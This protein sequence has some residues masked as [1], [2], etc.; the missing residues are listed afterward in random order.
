MQIQMM[1]ELN[2][3]YMVVSGEEIEKC[4][5]FRY[6]MLSAN[7]IKGLLPLEF[8]R[9]N[10]EKRIYIDVTG[11]E[12]LLNLMNVRRAGTEDI[13]ELF[14]SIYLISGEMQRF[15]IGETD[16]IMRPEMIFKNLTTGDYEF[17]CIPLIEEENSLN[18]GMKA[19]MHFL[20]MHINEN[21][22]SLVN[23]MYQI[24]DMYETGKP[25]FSLVYEFFVEETRVEEEE[26]EAPVEKEYE[27]KKFSSYIPG[28]KEI[29]ALAL[30]ISGIV[31]VGVNLYL[32]WL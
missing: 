4:E 17:I 19:L 15:L 22:E 8:R 27:E 23:T 26:E 10:N 1:Y 20:L 30:C 5:D 32:S 31:L 25:K 16:V 12:S 6:K 14:D 11:K 13:K 2:H 29:L 24:N 3:T 18:E 21:D 9:I 7:V 28:L